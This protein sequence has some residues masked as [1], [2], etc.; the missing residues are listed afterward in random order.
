MTDTPEPP[1][2]TL[3][4]RQTRSQRKLTPLRLALYRLAVPIGLAVIRF[5]WATCRVVRVLGADRLQQA[6]VAHGNVIPVYWHAHQLFPVR[7]LLDQRDRGLKL[8]FL[9]SPSVDGEIPALLVSKAGAQAIRGSSS[10][11][12]A[13]A[14]RDYYEAVVKQGISP[15]ITPDGPR[16]PRRE[17]KPGA[18]LI[19]QMTGRPLLP[20]AYAASRVFLFPTWDRFALP[21]P[22]A[23]IVLAVGEPHVVPK[24]LD[25]D[26][27]ARWQSAMRDELNRLYAEAQASLSGEA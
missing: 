17:F 15:A 9:I 4:D 18:I 26:A 24:G 21:W 23:R 3:Y 2:N 5:W 25:A 12:G 6:L 27:L 7:Y 11:T 16:G 13:R 10:N 1:R 14:L 19:A 22:F 20:M 8:G